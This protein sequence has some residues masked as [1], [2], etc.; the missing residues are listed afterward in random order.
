MKNRITTLYLIAAMLYVC[1]L[2][3]AVCQTKQDIATQAS[4]DIK[5]T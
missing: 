2:A 3:F 5:I 1:E 4:E